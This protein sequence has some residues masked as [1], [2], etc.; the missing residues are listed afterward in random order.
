MNREKVR[1]AYG[2]MAEL[3]IGHFGTTEQVDPDDLAFIRRHLASRPGTVLDLGCGPGH[4]TG[5][6]RS[7]GVDATGIDLVPEFIAHARAAHPNVEYHLGS[8]E[9]LDVP[10]N[11][12]DGILAW[13]SLIHL[14]PQELDGVLI[15]FRRAMAPAGTLVLGVFEADEVA[16][17]DHKVV[18]AYRWPIDEISERLGRAGFLE[19]E[20][21]PRPSDGIHRPHAAIAAVAVDGAR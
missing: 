16:A 10:D 2:S 12:V 19:V 7:L 15:E 3:Y 1:Q 5:Y 13:Y 14:P 4:L 8:L 9:R 17:F 6:L 20:R 11:S 21:L 18:T